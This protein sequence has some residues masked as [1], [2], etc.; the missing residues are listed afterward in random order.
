LDLIIGIPIILLAIMGFRNGFIKEIAAL[1]AL[2]LGLYF[3]IYFSEWVADHL[4]TYLDMGHRWLFII[5]FILTFVIVVLAVSLI[6]KLLNKI[7]AL[8]ALGI[9]NRIAGM[10]FGIAKGVLIMSVLILLFAMIDNRASILK[11]DVKEGSLLYQPIEK[12]APFILY[13]L[14]DIN[15][16]EPRQARFATASSASALQ[17]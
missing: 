7:A 3:A 5:A 10:L 15:Y 16:D 13:K 8:A 1:T 6:G 2:I 11:K 12:V 9:I 4:N 14:Q 17:M